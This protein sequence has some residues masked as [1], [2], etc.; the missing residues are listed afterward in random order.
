MS[1]QLYA[2]TAQYNLIYI[3]AIHDNAHAE[4]LKIGETSFTSSS[5]Y[6]QLPP[7]CP[8]LIQN[9]K[10]RIDQYTKTA[11]IQ[12]DLLYTELA[13]TQVILQDGTI[14][15]RAFS[16]HDVHEVL[17]RSGFDRHRFF[18]TDKSSEWFKV[19]LTTAKAA[20]RA[21][22]EGRNALSAA[23]I[24]GSQQSFLDTNL[25]ISASPVKKKIE[26]RDEQKACVAKTKK[27]FKSSDRMLWDCKMRFGK[28]VTAYAL[29]K[30]MNY[31]KVLV[32]THRPAVVD[33]WS[34]DF[35]LIFDDNRVFLTKANIKEEDRFT[36]E[37]ASIDADNDRQLQNLAT[38]N[39]P[40]VYFAS[41]QDLRGSKL[42]GGKFDKNRV[43]FDID[44]DIIIYDE[45]HEGTQTELGLNVQKLLEAP[46]VGKAPKKVLQLSGT[47]YNLINQYDDD[48]VYSWDYVMEQRAKKE[49]NKKYPGDHNPYADLPQLQICTFDLRDKLKTSYRYEEESIAFNFREFFRTWT[50]DPKHDFRQMPVGA[51]VGSFVHESDVRE[52]LNLISSDSADSN[53]PFATQEYRDMFKHTFW[54]LPGVKEARAFS[55]LLKEH[56]VFKDYEV[57]NVA[58]EGDVEQ[59]YDDALKAVRDAIKTHDRTITLSCGK[60][61]TGVTVK[62][63]TGVMLLS[64]SANTAAAGYMQTIFRVQS[65]GSIDG[66]QKKI[67]Y[68]FDFAP[69]RTLKV[70]SEVHQ[71]KKSAVGTDDNGRI[72]LGEF[73]NFCPVL[74]EGDT[75]MEFYDVPK[76]MRQLKRLTVDAAVKSGFDD[77]SIYKADAGIVLDRD[78]LQLI[79]LLKRK[80]TPQKKEKKQASVSINDQ[81]LTDEQ[82]KK[83]QDAKRKHKKDR[84]KEEKEALEKER[85][86]KKKQK[87]LF[88][89]LRNISIRLPLLIYG[90]ATDFDE[91]VKLEDF[92]TIV[93]DASWKE[94]MP[95]DVDKS[96]FRKLLVFY[97]EDVIAGAGMR[98]RRM[99]KAADELMPTQRVQRIAEIFSCFRNPA[100]ETVLTPWRVVNMHL[101]DTIGGYN[102]YK[103]GYPEKDG[104]LESPRLIEQGDVTADIFLNDNG[105]VLEMNSKSGLY[106]LYM[107]YSIYRFL[108]PKSEEEMTLEETQKIWRQVLNDH[109]FVLCQTKM[110][111]SITRRTLVGYTKAP[112]NAIF[113]SKLIDRMQDSKRLT[114]KITNPATWNKEGERMKFDA[115]VGNPPYQSI[116]NGGS[117]S[118]R[119]A[120]QAAPIFNLFVEQAKELSPRYLSMIIPARWYNGG[121][122]LN[123]FRC[124]MLKDKHIVKLVD[125]INSKDCFPTVDIGGGLCYFL[126]D[127]EH[128]SDCQIINV[129]GCNKNCLT[130]ALDQFENLFI[131]SNHAIPIIQKV[132]NTAK[133][134]VSDM[135][136]AIDTFGIPSKTRGHDN[137]EDGDI[138]LVHSDGANSSKTSYIPRNIVTKNHDLIDKYKVRISILVPQNG[139]AG[140]R[141]EKGYRSMSSPH[142]VYPGQVDSFSYLNIGFFDTEL[143][144]KN[145]MKYMMCKLPRYLMRTTYSSAHISQGNFIFVPKMD[146]TQVWD[147]K[148][149]YAQFGLTEEEIRLIESTMRPM[150]EDDS[151]VEEI[152]DNSQP[153]TLTTK[154][155]DETVVRYYGEKG[156]D[157]DLSTVGAWIVPFNNAGTAENICKAAIS[158]T[159]VAACARDRADAGFLYF[160]VDGTSE[161]DQRTLIEW[162][163][164]KDLL[165]RDENGDYIDLPYFYDIQT[166]TDAAPDSRLSDFMDLQT[167]KLI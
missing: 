27:V 35:T 109:L 26:L 121:I 16:D 95:Q 43:V 113:L 88:D 5:S 66:K 14:E 116:T 18:D 24:T 37:D 91:S 94:F 8:E 25:V 48:N 4:Y 93:D 51:A 59:P 154:V 63:W 89:L 149:L 36:S 42:A 160:Y 104:V 75:G 64:G 87:S 61:T 22:K 139:E 84:T 29:V 79:D 50:G 103:E 1:E 2:G 153:N 76:M 156:N 44:W 107:A 136:S 131:R 49:W 165:P 128:E 115:I 71:L 23:E 82:Y 150:E 39:Q 111:V 21:V 81:G 11:L 53:Y 125:F 58:G 141:P 100:K 55:A 57:V 41:M 143:E 19:D 65:A 46:K 105:K 123:S 144:A 130:R 86:M 138:L 70:L 56:P 60:L 99:A 74:A 142:I 31:Q 106:P 47:P 13:R 133:E 77:D 32:V 163:L 122:G 147:D 114:N 96:L 108:L 45:A 80:V 9:A 164:Q 20:I 129:S 102:F 166:R 62:Q 162:L 7:N 98:I 132:Q 68:A 110:A 12:Y 6:K 40:F 118:G 78:K 119:A 33:G 101:G 34:K 148:K 28:T 30:E 38:S 155:N 112:V 157:Y 10:A 83:A 73:L 92:I 90:T 124:D 161:A 146:F 67:C 152:P 151:D 17:D 3:F 134:F 85:E 54:I 127:K 117:D 72:L 15:S 135:V 158:D 167:G 69:D 126:W 97:D 145:F 159:I 120:R 140:I 52:F 137:Y